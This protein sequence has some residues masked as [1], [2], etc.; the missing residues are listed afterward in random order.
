MTKYEHSWTAPALP[1]PKLPDFKR[2]LRRKLIHEERAIALRRWRLACVASVAASL[3]LAVA[4]G[5]V[6]ARPELAGQLHT[7]V[8]GEPHAVDTLSIQRDREFLETLYTESSDPSL[9]HERVLA[10][11]DFEFRDGKRMTVYTELGDSG[12][13]LV[14]RSAQPTDRTLF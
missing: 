1:D 9:K 8:T 7:R 12:P 11:R 4:L 5:L 3:I 10:V 2:T 6:V 13:S 14:A